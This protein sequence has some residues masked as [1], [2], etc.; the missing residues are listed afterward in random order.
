MWPQRYGV[1]STLPLSVGGLVALGVVGVAVLTP[2]YNYSFVNSYGQNAEVTS[3]SGMVIVVALLDLVYSLVLAALLV[4]AAI[5]HRHGK[6]MSARSMVCIV[7]VLYVLSLAGDL[8]VTFIGTFGVNAN[9]V[10][11]RPPAQEAAVNTIA[12]LGL[13]FAA[14]QLAAAGFCVYGA[15]KKIPRRPAAQAISQTGTES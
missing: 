8:L 1:G 4:V 5:L 12:V 2:Y 10:A 7:G 11:P 14:L 6:V 3:G 15:W 9:A 13:L